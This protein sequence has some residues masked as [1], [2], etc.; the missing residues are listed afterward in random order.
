MLL[1]LAVLFEDVFEDGAHFSGS[2]THVHL[3]FARLQMWICIFEDTIAILF[4]PYERD[5]KWKHTHVEGP[6][7]T[8]PGVRLGPQGGLQAV[9]DFKC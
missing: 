1:T 9:R 5:T 3:L 4:F 2:R 8:Q 7:Q 6:I